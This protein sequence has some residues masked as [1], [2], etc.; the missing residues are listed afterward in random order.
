MTQAPAAVA[1]S[2]AMF[3]GSKATGRNGPVLVAANQP[4]MRRTV[5]GLL[6]H[7]SHSS[8]EVSNPEELVARMLDSHPTAVILDLDMPGIDPKVAL[9]TLKQLRP[10]TPVMV[11]TERTPIGLVEA[12]I[13]LVV[14]SVCKGLRS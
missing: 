5:R 6:E 8:I 9:G 3:H 2:H 4:G 1:R 13:K 10:T 11:F 14:P 7:V 12:W